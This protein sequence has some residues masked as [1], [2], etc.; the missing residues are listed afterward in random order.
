MKY[1]DL[2]N[3]RLDEIISGLNSP[4]KRQLCADAMRYSL[5]AGGKRIRPELL[6]EMCRI[7]GGDINK[8]ADIACAVEMMHTFSLIHDDL[9]CM[10]DD[11]MRRGKPSCHIQF[12]EAQALLAGDCLECLAFEVIADSPFDAQKRIA[13]VKSL[14]KAVGLMGMIGG[15]VIDTVGKC[16][17]AEELI[18]MY[19]MK[20]S[21][22]LVTACETGC[23]CAGADT[24][25]AAG[26]AENLGLAFQIIDDI[27]DITAD[28]SVLGKPPG[29]DAA[30]GKITVPV[31]TG[32]DR[33]RE[34]AAQYTDKAL[35]YAQLLPD[36][37][38]IKEL[39]L[40]LLDRK[41]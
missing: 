32:L 19:S 33:A 18:S 6:L 27:L 37:A 22:L 26:F 34:L 4:D 3:S 36:N 15:Q 31:L 38:Y 20:T 13:M 8:A 28:E 17:T 24:E 23:I 35:A 40:S 41:Y 2:V 39:A 21:A 14:S 29:S 12:G 5:F 1:T 30:Q 9:P 11:D 10:D 7:H 16:T 25:N